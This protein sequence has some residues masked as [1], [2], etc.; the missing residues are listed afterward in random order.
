MIQR[1][2]PTRDATRGS[3][4]LRV[5]DL[6]T[7]EPALIRPE[8]RIGVAL[9]T[10]E[11]ERLPAL[12]VELPTGLGILSARALL[13]AL[14]S[15][16]NQGDEAALLEVLHDS[17]AELVEEAPT[18]N[19]HD[20]LLAAA[21]LLSDFEL[22]A[23]PVLAQQQLVGLIDCEGVARGLAGG[24]PPPRS[25]AV[26]DHMT[27]AP[28]CL[29][30]YDSLARALE[31]MAGEGV[32]HVL[33][34]D[35]HEV[36]AGIASSRDLVRAGRVSNGHLTLDLV[37]HSLKDVMTSAPLVTV[38]PTTSVEEAAALLRRHRI[39]ALPVLSERRLVG[40]LTSDDLLGALAGE[41]SPTGAG[42]APAPVVPRR[43]AATKRSAS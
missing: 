22:P 23:L 29:R 26:S 14:S 25:E 32:R 8:T 31:F 7:R 2:Q 30:L 11:E 24:G 43:S 36:L 12:P 6:M 37:L 10:L 19:D 34:L 35:A 15:F 33:V 17:V 1:A 4:R 20:E 38:E 16:A 40:I 42:S 41:L 39:S 13:G 9:Q 28:R 27:P 3:R 18:C 5:R 21:K